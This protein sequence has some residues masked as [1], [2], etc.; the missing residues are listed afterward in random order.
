MTVPERED[1]EAALAQAEVA[2]EYLEAALAKAEAALVNT[3]TD[4]AKIDANRDEASTKVD[5]ARARCRELRAA[6]VER[7]HSKVTTRSRERIVTV[8]KQSD[9]LSKREA[10][11][12]PPSRQLSEP[13]VRGENKRSQDRS[14]RRRPF[15]R[16][17]NALATL[18][19]V[20][21]II[22]LLALVLAYLQYYFLDV[23][24]QIMRLPSI[25]TY[26][27]R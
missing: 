6:L 22:G 13:A 2:R 7:G 20:R 10:T 23:Q 26:L 19:H 12:S 11:A 14:R 1:L 8:I 9:E 25:T 27:P 3:V 21:E 4:A 17:H 15:H 5:K 18:P 24:V 16:F